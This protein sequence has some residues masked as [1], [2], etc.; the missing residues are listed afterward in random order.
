[1][2]SQR[3]TAKFNADKMNEE[4]CLSAAKMHPGSI[5]DGVPDKSK[6]SQNHR[7]VFLK[8][9]EVQGIKIV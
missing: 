2:E 8:L 4:H 9:P 6:S 3:T 1:M 5:E 7:D